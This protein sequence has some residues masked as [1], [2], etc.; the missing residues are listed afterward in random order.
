M[1]D[2]RAQTISA[3][4]R[5]TLHGFIH[6]GGTA[7]VLLL[8]DLGM[9]ARYWEPF[10]AAALAQEPTMAVAALDLRG[11]GGSELG[12]ETSRKRMVKD[13]RKWIQQ[14]NIDP[15]IVV[16]HGYGADIALAADF[17]QAVIAV[18]PAF[19]RLPAPVDADM[20]TPPAIR[21]PVSSD[22]LRM[23]EIGATAAKPLRR[24]RRDPESF[25]V[26]SD[27]ADFGPDA[28]NDCLE[29]AVDVQR[30]QN[31]SRH[32]P[33]ESPAGLAALVLGVLEEV[34]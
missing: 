27:P 14:L 19:G 2:F 32:L 13:L 34:A 24:G 28:L 30:W 12:T 9:D 29:V 5:C 1:L 31:G 23:C 16:G 26:L 25:F 17:V 7:P 6:D 11:H 21:G 15:P 22:A 18:N 33:I 8:H 4:D 20:A 10:L 3:D